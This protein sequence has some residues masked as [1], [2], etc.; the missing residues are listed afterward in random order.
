MAKP[1]TLQPKAQDNRSTEAETKLEKSNAQE[2]VKPKDDTPPPPPPPPPPE[3]DTPNLIYDDNRNINGGEYLETLTGTTGEEDHFIFDL[4]QVYDEYG[5]PIGQTDGAYIVGFEPGLDKIVFINTDPLG[6]T[7]AYP[8]RFEDDGL[9]NDSY[10]YHEEYLNSE[11]AYALVRNEVII[12]ADVET[13]N[14]NP[15]ASDSIA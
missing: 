12:L 9:L 6:T 14:Y 7:V 3:E 11:R 1:Q 8:D 5:Q 13:Y 10:A 2:F 4:Q 15:Y